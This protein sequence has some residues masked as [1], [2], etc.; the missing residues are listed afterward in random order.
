MI[1]GELT[2]KYSPL[3]A[4]LHERFIADRVLDT[5]SDIFEREKLAEVFAEE[6]ERF[7]LDVG[8]GGGQMVHR[9]HRLYP[10]LRLWGIDL[11]EELIARARERAVQEGN[12]LQFEVAN[13]QDLPFSDGKFDV[14]FSLFS[15]K[16]WPDP[17]QGIGECWR[18]LKAGGEL[19]LVDTTSDAGREQVL[20]VIEKM[21]FPGL[22]QKP[23]ARFVYQRLIRPSS[24]M[25]TYRQ[26][27]TQLEMPP[28]TVSQP[29]YIPTF[30]FRTQKP[31]A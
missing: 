9:L 20:S 18:V 3:E 30:L 4:W 2:R 22:L 11:S 12:S 1:F 31:E 7:V 10:H 23:A 27:S 25:E 16:H 19:L 6:K 8:C 14:V 29:S 5:Q 13:A 21:G 28:G 26:I 17:L 24:P 15:I